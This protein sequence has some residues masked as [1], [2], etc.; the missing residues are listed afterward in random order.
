MSPPRFRL[1]R[2]NSEPSVKERTKLIT[3]LGLNTSLAGLVGRHH[4]PADQ[5]R[6]LLTRENLDT[7]T[8]LVRLFELLWIIEANFIFSYHR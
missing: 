2:R 6:L 8:R 4:P 3:R 1:Q 7:H 5:E